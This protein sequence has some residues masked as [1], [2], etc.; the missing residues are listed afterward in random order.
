MSK[1]LK[2]AIL[3]Y[4]CPPTVGGVESIMSTHARLLEQRGHLPFIVAG[5]GDPPSVGL[6]GVILP[7]LDSRHPEIVRVQQALRED[8][9]MAMPEFERWVA[10]I[11]DLLLPILDGADVCIVHNAFTL[12]KNLA[13]T[14]AL[15]RLAEQKAGARHWIAWCHDLVW[16]NPL[17]AADLLPRWP[18]TALRYALPNVTYVAISQGRRAEMSE[19]FGIPATG[20]ALIPNG[21]DPTLYIP[22]SSEMAGIRD[23][24]R[25]DDRDWVLLAPVRVTRRKNLELGIDIVAA[26]RHNGLSPLFVVTGPL[27]PHNVRSGEYLDELLSRRAE[28]G[29][30]NEVAFL[31]F[32]GG[33]AGGLEVSDA[34]MA[35]L[36]WWADAMLLPS[37]QEGF[38]LPLLEAGLARLPVFCS[39]IPVLREVGGENAFYFQPGDDP[40]LIAHMI[41]DKL[42]KLKVA[43]HRRSVLSTYNW[44]NIFRSSF[45]PLLDRVANSES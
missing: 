22:T 33:P 19:L 16:N 8:E 36:Y 45:Q 20:I 1:P 10:R 4:A 25:W 6:K 42:S 31:A 18:W 23:R 7:E 27:G 24:L 44:D 39:D 9:A 11:C 2:I 28:K 34:L 5:R 35:E 13:L 41:S 32:E 37:N 43:N 26:M 40:T 17:Y 29:V 38:G 30:E 21:I 12:H 3:H 14:V 15:A